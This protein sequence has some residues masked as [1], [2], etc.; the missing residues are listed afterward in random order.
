MKNQRDNI[1][2]MA[3]DVRF[4]EFTGPSGMIKTLTPAYNC[5][6]CQDHMDQACSIQP[7]NDDSPEEAITEVILDKR[8]T[9]N[10]THYQVHVQYMY[11]TN[12]YQ[13]IK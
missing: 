10:E 2:C 12:F 5:R 8:I 4:V 7:E 9:R 11:I 13:P 3:K 6:F 1:I